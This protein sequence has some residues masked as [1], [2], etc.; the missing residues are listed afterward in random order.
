MKKP[1]SL[2]DISRFSFYYFGNESTPCWLKFHCGFKIAPRFRSRCGFWVSDYF[3]KYLVI[4]CPNFFKIIIPRYLFGGRF[5]H[6][7]SLVSS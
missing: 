2:I 3:T 5:T 6:A 7:F 4:R 1:K